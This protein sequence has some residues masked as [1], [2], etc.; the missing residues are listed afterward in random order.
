MHDKGF[1]TLNVQKKIYCFQ[2]LKKGTK[3]E[4]MLKKTNNRRK[5]AFFIVK[6]VQKLIYLLILNVYIYIFTPWS[7]NLVLCI[8]LGRVRG[9][10]CQKC[11]WVQLY[12]VWLC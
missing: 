1:I 9:K 12:G 2:I 8:Y 4:N 11:L 10:A 5:M 6:N 3:D 7:L